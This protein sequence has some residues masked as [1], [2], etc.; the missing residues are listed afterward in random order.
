M[1]RSREITDARPFRTSRKKFSSGGGECGDCGCGTPPDDD[2][3][4]G[5][6]LRPVI[7]TRRFERSM[8]SLR[9]K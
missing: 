1:N 6:K 5:D 2:G 9:I 8:R 4:G 3:G 7:P